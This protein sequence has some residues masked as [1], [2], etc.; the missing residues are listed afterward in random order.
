MSAHII[1]NGKE[2]T[3]PA[4]RMLIKMGAVL[5]AGLVAAAVVFMVLPLVGIA[6]TLSVGL[7][8]V[9]LIGLGIGLP[10]IILG[11]TVLGALLTPL[12]ALKERRKL[13]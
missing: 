4:A 8:G 11:S 1:I 7:V 9:V 10:L 13:R 2:V 12:A 6:V 5:L 3:H